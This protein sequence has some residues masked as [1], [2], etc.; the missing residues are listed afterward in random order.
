MLKTINICN[1]GV[2]DANGNVST[3]Q[4]QQNFL[5]H[6]Y[7]HSHTKHIYTDGSKSQDGVSFG[8][9][10]GQHL[11]ERI[12]GNLPLESSVFTAELQAIL[13]ALIVIETSIHLSW[14]IFTDSQSSIQ[15]IDQQ[16]P[17]HPLVRSIQTI[18][19]QLQD[20]HK[21]ICFC[22]VPSHVG[23]L[24]NEIADRTAN[25]SKEIPGLY[26]TRIPHRDYHLAIRRDIMR[27]WQSQWDHVDDDPS[28]NRNKLR[29]VKPNVKSWSKIPGE[30]RKHETK[31]TRLRIGHTR[32]TNGY[33]MSRGRPPECPQCGT[34]PLTTDH[35]LVE[36]QTTKHIRDRLK[37]PDDLPQ[38]T[39]G[40]GVPYCSS[41]IIFK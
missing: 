4:L 12:R 21:K 37:L 10:Y 26:T 2:S 16:N 15:A 11:N 7:K 30:N 29:I 3:L 36:C 22:K 40:R 5:S 9:V 25:E 18:L 41:Y 38:K 33:H 31:I 39:F 32:L 34:A 19:I 23:V 1:K 20:Q 28:G 27:R 24:G 35:F 17:R 13:R 14:T 6:M 8:V